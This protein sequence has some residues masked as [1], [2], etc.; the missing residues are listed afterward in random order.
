VANRAG[1]NFCDD[2]EFRDRENRAAGAAAEKPARDAFGDLFGPSEPA[3][4]LRVRDALMAH[5]SD[6]APSRQKFDDLFKS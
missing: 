6:P 3:P 2:F 5:P 4:E 1:L